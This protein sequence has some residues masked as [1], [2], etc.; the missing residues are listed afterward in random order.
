MHVARA[1]VLNPVVVAACFSTIAD[2]IAKGAA[3]F[4]ASFIAAGAA[5][6][7]KC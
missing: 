4:S 6:L 7:L 5:H 3:H 2:P 1:L